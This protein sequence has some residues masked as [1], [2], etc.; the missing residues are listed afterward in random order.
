VRELEVAA[1]AKYDLEGRFALGIVAEGEGWIYCGEEQLALRPG[2][3]FLLAAAAGQVRVEAA[4][5]D[6]LRVLLCLPGAA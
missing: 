1:A 3:C 5:G 4:T 2:S 6:A